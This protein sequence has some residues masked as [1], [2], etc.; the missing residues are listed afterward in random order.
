MYLELDGLRGLG[1]LFIVVRHLPDWNNFL[2]NNFFLNSGLLLK[3]FFVLSGFL[4]CNS[5][6][7]SIKSKKDFFRFIFLRFGR[8]Y[9]VHLF[10]L[11]LCVPIQLSALIS[12]NQVIS[13][14]KTPLYIVKLFPFG[15]FFKDLFLLRTLFGNELLF[16]LPSW[17]I[18]A[19]FLSYILFALLVLFF[20]KNKSLIFSFLF[21]FSLIIRETGNASEFQNLI[22][23]TSG[24]FMGCLISPIIKNYKV[25]VH[26]C[27]SVFILSLMMLFLLFNTKKELDFLFYFLSF[28]LILSLLLSSGGIIHKT[29]RS[30]FLVWLGLISY[31]IYMS[32]YLILL[33]FNRGLRIYLKRPEVSVEG[34][35]VPQLSFFETCAAILLVFL[36]VFLVSYLV[37]R[38]IE[39]PF[40]KKSREFALK[41]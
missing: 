30:R 24:F 28:A 13:D 12:K 16:N 21:I 17:S 31:S 11:L 27:F 33:V 39:E 5:Y 1:C 25:K 15:E 22:E 4:I 26:G 8:I 14:Y 6:G 19:E 40:R 20:N 34:F 35:M 2:K 32:H 7:D 37:N 29:L 18:S 3:L 41:I 36:V 38:F 10:F 23:C 9:S